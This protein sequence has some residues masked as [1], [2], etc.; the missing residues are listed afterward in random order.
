MAKIQQYNA[1]PTETQSAYRPESFKTAPWARLAQKG[2][3]HHKE[4]V[5]EEAYEAGIKDQQKAGSETSVERQTRGFVGS[6]YNRAYNK[7]AAYAFE[8]KKKTQIQERMDALYREYEND[9]EGFQA[10]A[11]DARAE[12]LE[13]VPVRLQPSLGGFYD[14]QRLRSQSAVQTNFEDRA[15]EEAAASS[16]EYTTRV[17]QGLVTA[18][19]TGDQE[20]TAFWLQEWEGVLQG[21]PLEYLTPGQLAGQKEAIRGAV[22]QAELNRRLEGLSPEEKI[23]TIEQWRASPPTLPEYAA[24]D[25]TIF[26]EGETL[27]I[28]TLE[29]VLAELERGA[30]VDRRLYTERM[31]AVEEELK[32]VIRNIAAG[33]PIP[34]DKQHVVEQL[35]EFPELQQQYEEAVSQA[36]GVQDFL[37]LT[38]PEQQAQLREARTR[39]QNGEMTADE[40]ELF[41]AQ[42]KANTALSRALG[43]DGL[44][45]AAQ[46]TGMELVP[47]ID[48]A[49]GFSIG[50]L[51]QRRTQQEALSKTFGISIPL[52]TNQEAT[53]FKASYQSMELGQQIEITQALAQTVDIAAFDELAE[54]LDIDQDVAEMAAMTAAPSKNNRL[55][56]STLTND[57]AIGKGIMADTTSWLH[58]DSSGSSY[59]D[60]EK[61][62]REQAADI[63]GFDETGRGQNPRQVEML[64]DMTNKI[65]AATVGRM[66]P[67]DDNYEKVARGVAAELVGM[68]PGE[69]LPNGEFGIDFPIVPGMTRRESE[70]LADEMDWQLFQTWAGETELADSYV[71]INGT[72][73]PAEPLLYQEGFFSDGL[74]SNFRLELLQPG[75]F[76]LRAP[77]EGGT[78]SVPVLAADGTQV[79][80]DWQNLA[81]N[82][83]ARSQLAAAGITL[84]E[85]PPERAE[86]EPAQQLRPEYPA[87]P[88]RAPAKASSAQPQPKERVPGAAPVRA[89]SSALSRLRREEG[90]RSEPYGDYGQQSVGYGTNAERAQE[91]FGRTTVSKREANILLAE[92]VAQVESAIE[93]M[94]RVPL[95]QD[96]WDALVLL[97]YNIGEGALASSTLI[98]RLNRGDYEG[99]ADEFLKWNKVTENGEKRENAGLTQR[100]RRERR[101][102]LG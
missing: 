30:V 44:S 98:E 82:P 55:A 35:S 91:R 9:P 78:R 21:D 27:D 37:N 80:L 50:A 72:K 62:A 3:R 84:P 33:L 11:D 36:E 45:V 47:I 8:A 49:G 67:T 68:A 97:G 31:A 73:Y 96:Q 40:Q 94:V 81:D 18:I 2:M 101:L 51:S 61:Y 95:N 87:A 58:T 23:E 74:T 79:V 48:Q 17:Q 14:A 54:T 32:P 66:K 10:A 85:T 24:G 34:A 53:A 64:N 19:Q 88:Q 43:E 52:M 76:G 26:R 102:F 56:N 59:Q 99:A 38:L 22:A 6:F 93:E 69:D 5:A 57:V 42:V 25:T 60:I 16:I 13:E 65:M 4:V 86:I 92:H 63:L 39:L 71:L 28:P 15:L 29:G 75:V 77:T 20:A 90:F 83:E 1:R 70:R 46:R 41:E 100:R 89:S 12:L 7:G